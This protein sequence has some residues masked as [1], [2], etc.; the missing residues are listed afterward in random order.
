MNGCGTIKAK[1][2]I[3]ILSRY[4]DL[5][6]WRGEDYGPVTCEELSTLRRN[7][8]ILF[9]SEL[10]PGKISEW[11]LRTDPSREIKYYICVLCRRLQ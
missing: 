11:T 4:A 1:A 8:V 2:K 7:S 10:H 6:E 5:K 3:P 9:E